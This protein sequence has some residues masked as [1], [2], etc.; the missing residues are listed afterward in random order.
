M[1]MAAAHHRAGLIAKG[2]LIDVDRAT[3]LALGWQ[4]T[5]TAVTVAACE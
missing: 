3:W 5:P 1:D 2:W 4:D